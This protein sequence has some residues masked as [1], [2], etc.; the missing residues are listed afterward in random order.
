[1]VAMSYQSSEAGPQRNAFVPHVALAHLDLSCDV[2]R[3]LAA[4]E[5]LAPEWTAL[6]ERC[7]L[8]HHVFLSFNWNWHWARHYLSS[9]DCNS[10]LG[11]VCLRS[12]GALIG[13][14][15]LRLVRHPG[16]HVIHW[17]GEPVSQY[18]DVLIDPAYR[19]AS[20]LDY[21]W[22]RAIAALR[23]DALHVRKVRADA[24]TLAWLQIR[25]AHVT[26]RDEAPY[27]DLASAPDFATYEERYSCK[28]RKNRRRLLRR[29]CGMG[30]VRIE[31]FT[32]G[33]EA[34]AAA[35]E[36]ITLKRRTLDDSGRLA[37]ALND[38]RFSAFFADAAE[39]ASHPCG[40]RVTRMTVDGRHVASTI[41]I[42]FNGHRAGHIIVHAPEFASCGPGLHMVEDWARSGIED[43]MTQL[44]LLAPAH[45]YKWDWADSAIA[46]ND[47]ALATSL[48]G[49]M[50]VRYLAH[51]RPRLKALAERYTRW[52]SAHR[53]HSGR[54]TAAA[55]PPDE[56]VS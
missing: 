6:H 35:L 25:R 5:L 21:G 50:F 48:R 15:P 54:A 14:W 56:K 33:P 16:M 37:V 18:G 4:F 30:E 22:A 42:N 8:G 31:H 43:G 26:Q 11:I 2:V 27:L 3:D 28:A 55:P 9:P 45:D 39:G 44:D 52:R 38:P 19:T 10:E 32:S 12:K 40:C 49:R 20:V 36:A 29:L 13:I 23:A 24:N 1:M 17:M 46:V 51:G 7:G 53:S 47:Y 41:D 34:R